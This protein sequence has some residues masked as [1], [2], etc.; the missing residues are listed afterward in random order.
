MSGRRA[1]AFEVDITDN[2]RVAKPPVLSSE[3]AT[4]TRRSIDGGSSIQANTPA[5]SGS[6][7]SRPA[8]A[9]VT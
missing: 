4:A 2:K 1:E 9:K 6:R 8:V 5:P 3:R 7:F